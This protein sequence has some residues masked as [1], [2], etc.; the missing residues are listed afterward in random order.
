MSGARAGGEDVR[1]AAAVDERRRDRRAHERRRLGAEARQQGPGDAWH[2]RQHAQREPRRA[3]GAAGE[4]VE[5]PCDGCRHAGGEGAR[6]EAIDRAGEPR[7]RGGFPGSRRVAAVAA[8]DETQRHDALLSE[9]DHCRAAGEERQGRV[10]DGSALVEH[11]PRAHA[12]IRE[13]PGDP[14]R[15]LSEGLLV[16]AEGQVDVARGTEPVREQEL[17]GLQDHQERALVV[18]RA[19]AV[20]DAVFDP[21]RK[22]RMRPSVGGVGGHDVIVRHQDHRIRVACAAPPIQQAALADA[23]PLEA[24]VGARIELAEERDELLERRGIR[25]ARADGGD[26][27]EPREALGDRRGVRRHQRAAK[28]PCTVAE[29]EMSSGSSSMAGADRAAP[30]IMAR[31]SWPPSVSRSWSAIS[32]GMRSSN[33]RAPA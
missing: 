23:L 1:R 6:V 22:R 28:R 3:G 19:S 14:G 29:I 17:D 27:D 26:A 15:G 18:E 31:I 4:H 9:P 2:P 32:S 12:A 21:A 33:P 30:A 16:S 8:G 11:E 20:H 24:R 10:H 13:Q 25:R 7:D 5:H